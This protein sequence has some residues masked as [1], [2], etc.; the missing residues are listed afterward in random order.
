MLISACLF[1]SLLASAGV[2]AAK[3]SVTIKYST[4]SL[5]SE[6]GAG[7]LYEKIAAAAK[8]VCWDGRTMPLSQKVAEAR[9][10]ESESVAKAVSDVK[11]PTLTSYYEAVSAPRK[12]VTRSETLASR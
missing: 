12:A 11:A 4:A 1:G 10:C 8:V 7:A 6:E 2:A 3:D 9:V 5:A